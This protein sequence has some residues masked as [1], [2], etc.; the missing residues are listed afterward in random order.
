MTIDGSLSPLPFEEI[1][2]GDI[3]RFPVSENGDDD[4]QTDG[5][6]CG[7]NGHYKKH[8]YLTVALPQLAG[9][10]HKR[11]VDRI[12]HQLDAHEDHDRVSACKNTN[13]PDSKEDG[14]QNEII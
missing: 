13:N 7:S 2:L 14:A 6:L 12:Q 9:E 1:N 11:E 4:R 8:E 10:R 5:Y 3:D